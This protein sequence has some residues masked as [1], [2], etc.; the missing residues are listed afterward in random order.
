MCLLDRFLDQ[1]F[2][3]GTARKNL[4]F[5]PD[6]VAY[7]TPDRSLAEE[8][9][10]M[11]AGVEGGTPHVITALVRADNPAL[12]DN[13]E[14]Q[15]LHFHPE[16]VQELIDMGHDCAIGR[17]NLTEIVIFGPHLFE[18]L[19]IEEIAMRLAPTPAI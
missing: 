14:M 5:Q 6:K 4:A 2:H 10:R 9:A 13:I 17:G 11:D 19:S 8:H 18:V 12:I 7:F 1:T 16:R 15:D 3:H